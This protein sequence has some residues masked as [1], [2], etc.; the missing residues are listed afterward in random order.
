MKPS[1]KAECYRI[2]SAAV[3]TMSEVLKQEQIL[4]IV[5]ILIQEITVLRGENQF[6][7]NQP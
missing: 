7:K 1:F 5:C 4:T 2:G 3:Y 6:S